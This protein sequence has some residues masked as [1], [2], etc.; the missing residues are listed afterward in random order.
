M[1]KINSLIAAFPEFN[2]I[3]IGQKTT[4]QK[5]FDKLQPHNSEFSFGYLF[6]WQKPLHLEVANFNSKFLIIRG[7][8]SSDEKFYFPPI[9][10]DSNSEYSYTALLEKLFSS[11]IKKIIC[12]DK[13]FTEII[14]TNLSSDSQIKPQREFYD[15]VYLA[16]DLAHLKGDRYQSKRNFVNRFTR[17]YKDTFK[18]HL[19]DNSPDGEKMIRH[20]LEFQDKWRQMKLS[21]SGGSSSYSLLDEDIAARELLL[22]F[23]EL[24]LC[25]CAITV[26]DEIAAFSIGEKIRQD[27][28]VIHVEKADTSFVGSYQTMVQLSAD[29][30]KNMGYRYINKEEDLGIPNLRKT[31]LSYHPSHFVEKYEIKFV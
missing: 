7:E 20:C 8:L 1:E 29:T 9:P 19:L 31:K 24:D 28:V 18:Y 3:S 26:K 5:I 17:K 2:P 22:N 30:I 12:A 4:F 11:P 27:T 14:K 10:T 16:D 6:S 15:Y 21:A 13:H 25:G 23:K